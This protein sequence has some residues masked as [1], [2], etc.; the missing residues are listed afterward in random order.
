M[1]WFRRPKPPPPTPRTSHVYF[2]D[3][4]VFPATRTEA[5]HTIAAYRVGHSTRYLLP[6]SSENAGVIA[7]ALKLERR[8]DRRALIERLFYS[9]SPNFG[10]AMAARFTTFPL[11]QVA[12]FSFGLRIS[13]PGFYE[14]AIAESICKFVRFQAGQIKPGNGL[15]IN[16]AQAT[17][18]EID[19]LRSGHAL[20]KIYWLTAI[21]AKYASITGVR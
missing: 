4:L 10:V 15:T 12:L 19:V 7:A 16:T 13:E 17:I 5:V 14:G 11:R 1:D 8:A 9:D 20:T 6:S 18:P 21:A 3:D 2:A